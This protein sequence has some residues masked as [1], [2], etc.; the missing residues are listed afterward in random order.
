MGEG[1]VCSKCKEGKE[2]RNLLWNGVH[3]KTQRDL[4]RTKSRQIS[5]MPAAKKSGEIILNNKVKNGAVMQ[6]LIALPSC[7]GPISG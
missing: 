5:K 4:R 6:N 7:C 2:T 3:G 1:P